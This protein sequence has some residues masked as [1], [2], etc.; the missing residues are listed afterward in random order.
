MPDP[1]NFDVWIWNS[2]HPEQ[3]SRTQPN[4][5]APSTFPRARR[6]GEEANSARS[7]NPY[8]TLLSLATSPKC[9]STLS[10]RQ[11]LKAYHGVSAASTIQRSALLQQLGNFSTGEILY[12]LVSLGLTKD[13]EDSLIQHGGLLPDIYMLS[14]LSL[15]PLKQAHRI[16]GYARTIEMTHFDGDATRSAQAER[17]LETAPSDS[18]II[19]SVPSSAKNLAWD[20]SLTIKARSQGVRG[21]VV[22]GLV[23]DL[24]AHREIGFSVFAQ[25][26]SPPSQ[27]VTTI[28]ALPSRVDAPVTFLPRSHMGTYSEDY[29]CAVKR[30]YFTYAAYRTKIDF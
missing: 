29:L 12:A 20:K 24:V 1:A 4:T 15:N 18:I 11:R 2:A 28:P 7:S 9:G 16:C 27:V 8:P 26:N 30:R 10:L 19:A 25:G 6:R 22:S 5:R 13:V 17:F 21:A 14:P 3:P 23:T